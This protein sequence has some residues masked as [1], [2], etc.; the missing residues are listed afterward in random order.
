MAA[1][2]VLGLGGCVD[3]ELKLSN[4]TLEQL[5]DLHHIRAAEL[6]TSAQVHDERDLVVSIL[7]HINDGGGGEHF[8][9][10][11]AVMRTFADRFP[12]RITLGG[13]S[14]RAGIAMSRLGVPTTLHLVTLNQHFRDLLPADCDYVSSGHADTFYPH[15]IVQYDQNIAIAAG[16]IDVRAS[17][18][19][20]LIYVNDPDNEMLRISEELG[21]LLRGATLLLVSGFNAIRDLQVLDARLQDLRRHLQQLPDG[22]LVYLEDAAYH[23]PAAN[24]HVRARVLDVIDIFGL[25]EDEMQTEIGRP[26]DLL[27]AVEVEAAI[28]DLR[29]LIPVPTLVLHTKHW[30]AAAGVDAAGYTDSLDIGMA[31]ASTR[32]SHGDDYSDEQYERIA[33]GPRGVAATRFAAELASRMGTSVTCRP[34]FELDVATPTT[35]GLG[36]AFVGGFLTALARR[37]ARP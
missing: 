4:R 28:N 9:A 13:T 10:S 24:E 34:G 31:M 16:D 20:R 2:V 33:A 37:R 6:T 30:S 25:N 11:P 12:H 21:E 15:L 1:Q 32:Y 36:D 17:Y 26:V 3:I 8:V 5:I 7:A 27:S 35:V 29:R 22:A 14:V 19:N 18:A 23:E